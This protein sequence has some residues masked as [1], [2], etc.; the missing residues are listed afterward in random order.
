MLRELVT[1]AQGRTGTVALSTRGERGAPLAWTP[2]HQEMAKAGRRR[3]EARLE[4]ID[5]SA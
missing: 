1:D 2:Q 3:A 4:R 5:G